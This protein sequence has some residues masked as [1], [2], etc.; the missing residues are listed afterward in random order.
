MR[1][2]ASGAF[3]PPGQ[4]L[5]SVSEDP[6]E[7]GTQYYLRTGTVID[8]NTVRDQVAVQSGILSNN[9][10]SNRID[11]SKAL[12]VFLPVIGSVPSERHE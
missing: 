8:G 9:G 7:P 11:P 6:V 5:E 10:P 1:S 3:I 4:T 12:A 2:G